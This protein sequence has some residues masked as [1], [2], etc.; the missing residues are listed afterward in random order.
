MSICELNESYNYSINQCCRAKKKGGVEQGRVCLSSR[1]MPARRMPITV[2]HMLMWESQRLHSIVPVL[3][4][5][6]TEGDLDPCS[7]RGAMLMNQRPHSADLFIYGLLRSNTYRALAKKP[8]KPRA[9]LQ[10]IQL[11]SRS[12]SKVISIPIH[13]LRSQPISVL[14][15]T[16]L[17]AAFCCE[18]FN[19]IIMFDS[20]QRRNIMGA[21]VNIHDDEAMLKQIL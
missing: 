8:G 15:M 20:A 11:Q 2:L 19:Y 7:L 18:N 1:T 10:G 17:F 21:D 9:N 13:F 6:A 16:I 14:M 4:K 5:F 12:H 3:H